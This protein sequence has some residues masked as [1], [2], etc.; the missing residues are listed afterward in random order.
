MDE[1]TSRSRPLG[2]LLRTP[3]S[4]P[5][6]RAPDAS[7][8][9]FPAEVTGSAAPL[10]LRR[11]HPVGAAFITR[12]YPVPVTRGRCELT[13]VPKPS[14]TA[15]PAGAVKVEAGRRPAAAPA[16]PAGRGRRSTKCV[17]PPACRSRNGAA[18]AA[19][20]LPACVRTRGS[21]PPGSRLACR[22]G[23]VIRPGIRFWAAPAR[24]GTA[25]ARTRSFPSATLTRELLEG[26]ERAD[27]RGLGRA[28][29][30]PEGAPV[31]PRLR[32]RRAGSRVR[33]AGPRGLE[34]RVT[35]P[36][37]GP[38]SGARRGSGPG[39]GASA[40]QARTLGAGVQARGSACRDGRR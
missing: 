6:R 18:A 13:P 33:P 14:V 27:G 11:T 16:P 35:G 25:L 36:H 39:G 29:G 12:R 8:G 4:E 38:V 3:V 34:G 21:R 15:L 32:P 19:R 22:L 37:L 24:A 17:R 40:S 7:S 10:P 20:A 2:S 30:P 9:S 28:R 26:R 31:R 1:A 5:P 23:R